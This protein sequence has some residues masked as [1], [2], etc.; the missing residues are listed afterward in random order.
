MLSHLSVKNYA[1]IREL[2]VDFSDGFTVITGETGSG[3]SILLGALNLILGKRA[4]STILLNKSRKCLVEATFNIMNCKL[5]PF[6]TE[7]DLDY[8]DQ[9][10]IRREIN[11]AGKSR[12]FINDTPVNLFVLK[13]IGERLIDIHSQGEHFML[14]E[15]GFQLGV[16]DSF[17]GIGEE[18][19]DFRANYSMWS[20]K[21]DDLIQ[22]KQAEIQAGLEKDYLHFV[23]KELDEA[24]LNIGEQAHLEQELE[25]L[26]HAGEIKRILFEALTSLENEDNNV[27]N[28][29][30]GLVANFAK[31]AQIG[32]S[33]SDLSDR[34]Q[35]VL[36][37][38]KDITQEIQKLE[39]SISHQPGRMEEVAERL[40]V[41]Y[42]LQAK[43]KVNSIEAL[44]E[45]KNQLVQKLEGFDSVR[46]QIVELEKEIQ[47][48]QN[49]LANDAERISA[50]RKKAF[51]PFTEE[52][53]RS[54]QSLGIPDA[55]FEI[56]HFVLPDLTRNGVDQITFMFNANKGE[57]LQDMAKVA[58]GGEKSRL[59]L[60]VKSLLS[61]KNLLS[62]II[63]DEIDSGVSG[64]V[65]ER[66]GIIL[67]KLSESMQ[68]IAITHLPQIAG[69]GEHHY[70]VYKNSEDDVTK[71]ELKHLE[72]DERII[73]I[74][75]LLS[76]QKL[77]PASI[78]S[79][80][81]LLNK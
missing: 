60:T 1:L 57:K 7:N 29:I 12:A 46:S 33:F 66:V 70:L 13:D 51:Y 3:K 15:A 80:R 22:L 77:T 30:S 26:K 59:M 56:H 73:E 75:K 72:P 21:R 78:E 54:L 35:S 44:L 43:H 23:L 64:A 36:I 18:V 68:V 53:I 71:T 79:A 37:D 31:L 11:P 28:R 55:R 76:G 17:S 65:A 24:R 39:E 5:E 4:D 32:K 20:Q 48:I 62:T 19:N 69:M 63:F 10:I 16:I 38:L 14:G 61:K 50:A 8:E 47:S 49:Q 67:K 58:S 74:A 34:T 42:K 41:I 9:T 6:F 52:M 27:L 2:E 25:V 45:L 40:D 81:Y